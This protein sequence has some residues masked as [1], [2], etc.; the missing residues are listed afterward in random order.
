MGYYDTAL[1]ACTSML[2]LHK[3]QLER[4]KNKEGKEG[5]GILT[6]QDLNLVH[7]YRLYAYNYLK[8]WT[9]IVEYVDTNARYSKCSNSVK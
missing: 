4:N 2:D 3:K 9:S 8:D 7:L 6:I 5:Q 1:D